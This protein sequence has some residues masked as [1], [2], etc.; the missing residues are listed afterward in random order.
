MSTFYFALIHRVFI[1]HPQH[2]QQKQGLAPEEG[3]LLDLVAVVDYPLT[4]L[5]AKDQLPRD[6]EVEQED[7]YFRQNIERPDKSIDLSPVLGLGLI[8]AWEFETDEEDGDD[9]DEE[10]N[11]Q[12]VE[13]FQAFLH[14]AT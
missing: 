5:M 14:G 9:N 4:W 8:G 11:R 2:L 12:V 6:P 7:N 10:E 13:T 3:Y 1:K